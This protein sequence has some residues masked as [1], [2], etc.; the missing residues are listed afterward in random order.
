MMTDEEATQKI[1]KLYHEWA[2][3]L[4]RHEAEWFER[5]IAPDFT[6]TTHPF[7]GLSLKKREFIE[8]DMQ[9][10][11]TKIKFL[12]IRAHAVGNIITSQAIAE[13]KE[14]F[15]ADL[16]QGMPSA[17]EVSQLLSGK[18]LAYAS[19][20]RKAGDSWQCF[21]HHLIGPVD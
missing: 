3:A 13:V 4:T 11:N 12:E 17:A 16:G 18:T 15:K 8:V 9:I 19:A 6:L 10:Q 20:W 7:F 5:H 14:D 1:S 21:D 2:N